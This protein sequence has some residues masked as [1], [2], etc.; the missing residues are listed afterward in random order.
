[1][2]TKEEVA[3][4]FASQFPQANC[5]IHAIGNRGATVFRAIGD[6]DLRPGGTVAGPVLMAVADIALY[7][8]ILGEAGIVPMAVTTSFTINFL[9]KPDASKGILEVCKLLKVGRTQVVGEVCLYS[10]GSSVVL[11]HAT[12][13]YFMP[14]T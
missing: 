10:E 4:F 14:Q 1:M 5:A 2:A 12:G 6:A 11:A 13:T 8:A 9:H 7:A 3:A